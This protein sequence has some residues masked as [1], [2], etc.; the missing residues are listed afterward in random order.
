MRG[1][2]ATTVTA[3]SPASTT[4]PSSCTDG[5]TPSTGSMLVLKEQDV[6]RPE[7]LASGA[8]GSRFNSCQAHQ[9]VRP[10]LSG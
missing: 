5:C 3:S 1:G 7:T 10:T 6:G 9:N 8:R 4:R 2:A